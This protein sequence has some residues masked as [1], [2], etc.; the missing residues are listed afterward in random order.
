MLV[1]YDTKFSFSF[2]GILTE[3]FLQYRYFG[4]YLVSACIQSHTDYLDVCGEPEFLERTQLEYN[5]FAVKSGT[6]V[7][8]ACG[9]DSIPSDLGALFVREELAR[10]GAKDISSVSIYISVL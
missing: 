7:I 9:F 8:G 10:R 2:H 3:N 5:D 6:L 1:Q 4:S